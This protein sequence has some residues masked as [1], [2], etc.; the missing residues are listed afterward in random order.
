[1]SFH[2]GPNFRDALPGRLFS[3]YEFPGP[4]D[5][6]KTEQHQ[7]ENS[8]VRSYEPPEVVNEGIAVYIHG[9]GW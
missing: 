4:D 5:R 3:K 7:L 8:W 2:I 9:G 1:M 6:V